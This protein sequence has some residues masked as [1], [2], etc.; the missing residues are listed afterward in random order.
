VHLESRGDRDRHGREGRAWHFV[1][2]TTD[3]YVKFLVVGAIDLHV[4]WP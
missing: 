3:R 1:F 4:D 2:Q